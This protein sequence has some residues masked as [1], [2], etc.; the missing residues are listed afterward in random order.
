MFFLSLVSIHIILY[1]RRIDRL[2][3][4]CLLTRK[5][6][7]QQEVSCNGRLASYTQQ[8]R[9]ISVNHNPNPNPNPNPNLTNITPT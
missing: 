6:D 3:S 8:L 2:R 1:H 9:S 4:V 7:R 5:D